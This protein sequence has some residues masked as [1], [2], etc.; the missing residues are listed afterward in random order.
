MVVAALHKV[1]LSSS[2]L[3]LYPHELSGGMRQRVSLARA[4]LVEP[5]LIVLDEPFANLDMSSQSRTISL[6]QSLNEREKMSFFFISH[7]IRAAM[8]LCQRIYVMK[9]GMIVEETYPSNLF[10]SANN[11][12]Q[13]LLSGM[14][15]IDNYKK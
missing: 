12:T 7:D 13:E 1:G 2:T 10:Q 14:P 11:Y 6:I 4:L 5:E 8:A 3:S 9:K 15:M